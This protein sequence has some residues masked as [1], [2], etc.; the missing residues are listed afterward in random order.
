MK[1]PLLASLL[2]L[3]AGASLQG[4]FFVMYDTNEFDRVVTLSSK[5]GKLAGDM[6]FVEGPVWVPRD[7][8]YLVFSDIPANELKKWSAKEDGVTTFRK[9]SNHAN[10]NSLDPSGRLVT[11]EHESR[12]V[13]VTDKKG[14]VKTLVD[15]F[16]GKKFNSPNDVVVKS[17]GSVWFTDPDYGLGN[18]P[19]EQEGNFVYRFVPA[20]K[21]VHLAAR[22]FDKPNGLCFSPDEKRLYVADSGKPRHIRFFDVQKNGTLAG[23]EVFAQI[24]RGAPDGIRCDAVGRLYS[25]AADGVYIFGPDG[26]L[27]GKFIVPE[28]PAN[29]AFGGK[30]RQTLFITARSSL[31]AIR[32]AVKGAKTGG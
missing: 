25:T 5:L 29:L 9:P 15:R 30:D 7:G 21:Q 2:G 17:D 12:C 23:G 6:Q 27:I 26:K 4:Q 8:G 1:V 32:L 18:N 31:Y 24:D 13:T 16:E 11:A 10:G 20:K 3:V 22:D 19:K 28:T 14:T